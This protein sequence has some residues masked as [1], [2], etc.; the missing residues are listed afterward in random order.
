MTIEFP[1]KP[2]TK[3]KAYRT[4]LTIFTA[5]FSC[6]GAFEFEYRDKSESEELLLPYESMLFEENALVIARLSEIPKNI[7]IFFLPYIK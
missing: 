1:P 7:R 2:T 6:P 4:N 5:R 3:T